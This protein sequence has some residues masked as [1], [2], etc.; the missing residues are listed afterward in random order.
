MIDRS[1]YIDEHGMNLDPLFDMYEELEARNQWQDI[2]TAPKDGTVIIVTDE[3]DN[4]GYTHWHEWPCADGST[5][6]GW[7]SCECMFPTLWM[8][9]PKKP[10]ED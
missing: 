2:E 8:S 3:F 1:K 7:H 6:E 5:G 9:P 4:L 10:K